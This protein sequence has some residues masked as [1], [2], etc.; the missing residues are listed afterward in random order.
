VLSE[1][2]KY[3]DLHIYEVADIIQLQLKRG[4]GETL[5]T[6][7]LGVSPN[8]K[9]SFNPSAEGLRGIRTTRE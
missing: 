6:G 4:A 7:D 1:Y 5:L 2:Y 8:F 9:S 3:A